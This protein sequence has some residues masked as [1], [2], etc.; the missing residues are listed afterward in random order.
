MPTSARIICQA[1]SKSIVDRA[2]QEPP[3]LIKKYIVVLDSEDGFQPFMV[4][5]RFDSPDDHHCEVVQNESSCVQTE[6]STKE[7]GA[8]SGPTAKDTAGT[9]G[10]LNVEF[11][12]DSVVKP[13][14]DEVVT[15]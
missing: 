13:R 11:D 7:T 5:L 9:S 3:Q 12:S 4:Y 2:H 15:N 6:H 8:Q 14:D 10:S 1:Q